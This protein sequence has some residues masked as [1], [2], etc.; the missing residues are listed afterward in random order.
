MNFSSASNIS[1]SESD[2]FKAFSVVQIVNPFNNQQYQCNYFFGRP[3]HP[4]WIILLSPLFGTIFNII[5][6]NI[7][8]RLFSLIDNSLHRCLLKVCCFSEVQLYKMHRTITCAKKP[9]VSNTF[10]T[11][12]K[13]GACSCCKRDGAAVHITQKKSCARRCCQNCCLTCHQAGLFE[14]CCLLHDNSI[15]S[16]YDQLLPI[17][18]QPCCPALFCFVWD[19]RDF[20]GQTELMVAAAK[21]KQTAVLKWLLVRGAD[22]NISSGPA[23]PPPPSPPPPLEE[24]AYFP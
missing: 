5:V 19:K 8:K 3:S 12:A 11:S 7:A 18:K 2:F 6:P 17:G 23:A 20:L 1:V 14:N 4:L 24:K 16:T 13:H 22:P 15:T 10:E 9:A 21:G